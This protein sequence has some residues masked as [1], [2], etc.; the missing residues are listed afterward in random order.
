M[1]TRNC[2]TCGE[3]YSYKRSTSRFCTD[4]CRWRWNQI[5]NGRYR[6][7][8]D[9][10]FAV[11]ARDNFRCVYCGATPQQD[12]LRVDHIVPLDSGGPPLELDNLVTSCHACN[13]GKGTIEVDTD[14]HVYDSVFE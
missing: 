7:P 1:N 8:T 13:A 3:S 11:L 10:R 2:D 9:I 6:I 12:E 4:L 14:S 5:E